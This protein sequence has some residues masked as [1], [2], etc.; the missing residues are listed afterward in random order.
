MSMTWQGFHQG[1]SRRAGTL[2]VS[3]PIVGHRLVPVLVVAVLLL[4]RG[5]FFLGGCRQWHRRTQGHN[6]GAPIHFVASS[7]QKAGRQLSRLSSGERPLIHSTTSWNM[8]NVMFVN[9]G[10]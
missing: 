9:D 10:M 4:Y 3:V 2:L 5:L 6:L 1:A 8:G 7:Q